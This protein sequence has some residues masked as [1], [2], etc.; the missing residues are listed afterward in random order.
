MKEEIE[1]DW[2]DKMRETEKYYKL[3]GVNEFEENLKKLDVYFSLGVNA[4][5]P[6]I[7]KVKSM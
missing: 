4:K 3:F 1:W 7:H 5:I 6:R 2:I